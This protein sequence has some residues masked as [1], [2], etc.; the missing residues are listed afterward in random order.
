M[1]TQT[2]ISKLNSKLFKL[3]VAIREAVQQGQI[4]LLMKDRAKV[5]AQLMEAYDTSKYGL[6]NN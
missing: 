3:D 1:I 2:E 6:V 4:R 5:E